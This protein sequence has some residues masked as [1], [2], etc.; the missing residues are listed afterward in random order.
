MTIAD[1]AFFAVISPALLTYA[2]DG[3]DEEKVTFSLNSSISLY[4]ICSRIF[5]PS[6]TVFFSQEVGRYRCDNHGKQK[7]AQQASA[8]NASLHLLVLNYSR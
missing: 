3:F 2:T 7:E 1:P 8:K 4:R 5:V 6:L